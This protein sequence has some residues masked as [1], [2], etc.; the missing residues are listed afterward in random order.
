MIHLILETV[1]MQWCVRFLYASKIKESN[2]RCMQW[3][4]RCTV[5]VGRL[6]KHGQGCK[7]SSPALTKRRK[8]QR[9]IVYPFEDNHATVWHRQANN[10]FSW[11]TNQ[12]EPRSLLTLTHFIPAK[13]SIVYLLLFAFTLKSWNIPLFPDVP[14][15]SSS[16]TCLRWTGDVGLG[17][18]RKRSQRQLPLHFQ[19]LSLLKNS[20]QE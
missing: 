6:A 1:K 15:C 4:K 13:M 16:S 11:E 2:L 3:F 8:K 17:Y 19:P 5:L 14:L 20:R 12:S 10:E 9:V 7:S 18:W